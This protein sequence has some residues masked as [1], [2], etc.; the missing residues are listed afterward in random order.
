MGLTFK[1]LY[2]SPMKKLWLLGVLVCI[3]LAYRH[4]KP[5][6]FFSNIG[7]DVPQSAIVSH[8]W[9]WWYDNCEDHLLVLYAPAAQWPAILAKFEATRLRKPGS[10]VSL[11]ISQEPLQRW[12][13]GLRY[14]DITPNLK[15]HYRDFVS[16]YESFFPSHPAKATAGQFRALSREGNEYRCRFLR[17]ETTGRVWFVG[18]MIYKD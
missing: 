6:T 8:R 16:G 3:V 7:L 1:A 2:L 13:A 4:F 15:N 10:F 14:S 12:S 9:I 17:D 11:P 5:D 18:R